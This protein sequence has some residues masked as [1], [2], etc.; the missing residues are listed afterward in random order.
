MNKRFFLITLFIALAT[1]DAVAEQGPVVGVGASRLGVDDID[2]SFTLLHGSVGYRFDSGDVFSFTPEL[3]FGVGV[4][5][6]DFLGV[7]FEVDSFYG[8]GVRGEV[9]AADAYVFVNPT[10]TNFQLDGSIG[11]VTASTDDWSFGIGIG[12]G[13]NLSRN[14]SI[15]ISYEAVEDADVFGIGVRF[16]F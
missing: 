4:T 10:Y 11:G 9:E 8:F 6:D 14:A 1:T 16:D 5:D 15:E 13:M 12:A 7:T 2:L 3:R